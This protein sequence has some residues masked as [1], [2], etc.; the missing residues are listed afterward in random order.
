LVS[1]RDIA[2]EAGVT[3]G[4]VHHYYESKDALVAA[5]L[6]SIATDIDRV[7]TD[8]LASTGDRGEMVRAVWQM[9]QERPAFP[10][11]VTWWLLDG[12]NVTEAMGDH[13][14]LR[15]LVAS[16]GGAQDADGATLAG[17]VIVQILGGTVLRVGINRALGRPIDDPALSDMM[18]SVVMDTVDANRR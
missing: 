4:L 15:R 10:Y 18:E 9:L 3:L 13:P 7:A 5:T 6:R 17:V 8:A 14:F 16:L 12:R 1:V 11:I 2:A